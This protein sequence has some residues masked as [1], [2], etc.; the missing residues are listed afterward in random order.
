[1]YVLVKLHLEKYGNNKSN[2]P[3]EAQCADCCARVKEQPMEVA[4]IVELE[5]IWP[6][7]CVVEIKLNIMK[8]DDLF[9]VSFYLG[10]FCQKQLPAKSSQ[11]SISV[12]QLQQKSTSASN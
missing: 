3:Y 7:G 9:C 2:T 10:D 5:L 6:A 4:W 8:H 11:H 12:S 1:M